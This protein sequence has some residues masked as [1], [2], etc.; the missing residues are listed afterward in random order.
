MVWEQ[1]EDFG[2]TVVGQQARPAGFV[3]RPALRHD[4]GIFN[5]T[6]KMFKKIELNLQDK[7]W[8]WMHTFIAMA[9]KFL[10]LYHCWTLLRS[11][12]YYRNVGFL[13]AHL[14]ELSFN[15]STLLVGSWLF[16]IRYFSCSVSFGA[17]LAWSRRGGLNEEHSVSVHCL[18]DT[19]FGMP[20]GA[21]NSKH[22]KTTDS[23]SKLH[24]N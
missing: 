13:S 11:S 4:Q 12:L 9:M 8:T 20:S 2:S 10:D 22:A 18:G 14:L 24:L 6:R 5:V 7:W 3:T 19:H 1:C 15:S 17:C 23:R 21:I 16:C